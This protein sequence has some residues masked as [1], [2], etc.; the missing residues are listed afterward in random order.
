MNN[1]D[2]LVNISMLHF[3][4]MFRKSQAFHVVLNKITLA[5]RTALFLNHFVLCVKFFF[6]LS[7]ISSRDDSLHLYSFFPPFFF[8]SPAAGMREERDSCGLSPAW[9]CRERGVNTTEAP[10]PG[11]PLIA[12]VWPWL[13]THAASIAGLWLMTWFCCTHIQIHT[14]HTHTCTCTAILL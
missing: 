11:L 13:T 7:I 14:T 9:A 3:V 5:F 8:S 6:C 2:T 1:R 10:V 4:E 12:P